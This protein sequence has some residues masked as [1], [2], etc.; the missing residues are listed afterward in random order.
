VLTAKE[1]TVSAD[2]GPAGFYEQTGGAR[3]G[4]SLLGAIRGGRTTGATE[5]SVLPAAGDGRVREGRKTTAG[6]PRKE[7]RA[8][9]SAGGTGE[10]GIPT[11]QPQPEF[12]PATRCFEVGA[13]CGSPAQQHGP[14]AFIEW[15]EP[16]AFGSACGAA[17]AIPGVAFAQPKAGAAGPTMLTSTARSSVSARGLRLFRSDVIPVFYPESAQI[18]HPSPL[19]VYPPGV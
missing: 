17:A 7:T 16:P 1:R 13:V 5:T 2:G 11:V 8:D 18:S 6:T 4:V 19:A 9:E 15:Q 14:G 12:C 10:E 3:G